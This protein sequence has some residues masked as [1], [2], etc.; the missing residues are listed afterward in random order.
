MWDAPMSAMKSQT[1]RDAVSR[2]VMRNLVERGKQKLT[3]GIY[4]L[5]ILNAIIYVHVP[6]VEVLVSPVVAI[7]VSCVMTTTKTP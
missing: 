6:I 5:E 1:L 4:C 7:L 2:R 3:I